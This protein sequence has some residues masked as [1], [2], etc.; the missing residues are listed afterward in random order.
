MN[1]TGIKEVDPNQAWD[2]LTNNA[3]SLMIDVRTSMEWDRI[4]I[5]DLSALG[6][7]RI[8]FIEWQSM[9]TMAID[10]DFAPKATAAIAAA[11]A[12]EVYFICRSGVRSLHAGLATT[13]HAGSDA[14]FECFNVSGGF[15]G[16]PDASGLRGRINGWQACGLPWLH[17]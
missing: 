13:A 12:T 4:G 5:P 15:E 2:E 11:G 16:D 7:D 10:S 6:E 14:G 8:A 9:P 1:Q 3:R 17:G